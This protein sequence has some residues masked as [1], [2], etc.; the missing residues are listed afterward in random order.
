PAYQTP[1]RA[2]LTLAVW[3]S[4]LVFGVAVLTATDVLAVKSPFDRLTDFAM[5]GAVIFETLAVLS[6]FVLR[7]TMPDAPR[8]YRCWGYP[9][10]PA[11]YVILPGFILGNLLVSAALPGA[12]QADQ[13]AE[14]VAGV[15]IIL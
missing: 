2:I 15:G 13:Q 1:A 4:L 8:P 7:R 6:V 5:F 14:V 12:K 9:W 10:V 11:L 3:A